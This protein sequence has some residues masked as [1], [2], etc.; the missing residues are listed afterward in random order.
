MRYVSTV[1]NAKNINSVTI[2]LMK[3]TICKTILTEYKS[4]KG[5][6]FDIVNKNVEQFSTF[7]EGK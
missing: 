5:E 6:N 3:P 7:F 1:D 2:P 4:E